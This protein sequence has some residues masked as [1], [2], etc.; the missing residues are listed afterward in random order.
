MKF[1]TG[2]L[3]L[4]SI[5]FCCKNG[6]NASA[7]PTLSTEWT[8]ADRA[9]EDKDFEFKMRIPQIVNADVLVDY[10]T[11]DGTALSGVDYFSNNGTATI[12]AG[13]L[14]TNVKVKVKGD[15][16]RRA[17]QFFYLE[18][19]NPRNCKIANDEAVGI[20]LND[21]T[22]LPLDNKGYSTPHS[23]PNYT[24][25][26]SDEFNGESIDENNWSFETGGTGWGNHEL[27]YYS[28]RTQNAF[29]SSG[30][31][32]IEARKENYSGADFTSAR[33]TTKG[34][35]SFKYGR[36]DIRAKVPK[37]K[38]TLSSLW[39]LGSN[40]DTAGWPTCGE[41][42]IMQ[43]GRIDNQAYQI[44]HWGSPAAPHQFGLSQ[45]LG[46]VAENDFHVFSCIWDADHFEMYVDDILTFN[47]NTD[48]SLPFRNQFFLIF[49]LA[50]G[51][52]W[53]GSPDNTTQFPQRMIVDYVRI[54]Q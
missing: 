31:L 7:L 53:P 42:D 52:D 46:N 33:L 21:G 48:E 2:L 50:V 32:I 34:K 39:M 27:E 45:W 4:V 22:Y 16:V 43:L 44:L 36:I 49:S 29:V 54:F 6:D 35:R 20:I 1:V 40:I 30:N 14:Y 51:G 17:P 47:M 19:S 23:Y 28:S 24:L 10:A 12:K 5:F 13:N 18:I 37:P 38:G 11:K 25:V 8:S 15:S 3:L 26:W 41:I 9:T